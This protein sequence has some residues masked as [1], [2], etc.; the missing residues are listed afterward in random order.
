MRSILLAAAV[1]SLAAGSALASTPV[2]APNH[3]AYGNDT[4]P[5]M[6]RL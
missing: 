4:N 2:N 5:P 1:L 6:K 3:N